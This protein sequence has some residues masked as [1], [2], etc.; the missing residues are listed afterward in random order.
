[1]DVVNL[2]RREAVQ[3]KARILRAERPQQIFIPLDAEIRMQPALHQNAGAAQRDCLVN[4]CANF[5]ER[6]H[7]SVGRAR[8]PV[9]RAESADDIADVRVVDVAIDD[10]GDDVVAGDGA[11]EFCQRRRR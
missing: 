9:E 5:V 7:V 1:M 6:A 11:G 4:L 10:V 2:G 8:P 3:L